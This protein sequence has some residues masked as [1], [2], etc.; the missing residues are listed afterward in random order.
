MGHR[1]DL[2]RGAKTC[3]L[4]L[5]YARTTARDI[6][7]ASGT[8]LASIG[9]HFGSKD[10]LM[11]AAMMEL[12]GDWGDR[13]SPPSMRDVEMPSLQRFSGAWQRLIEQFAAD[14]QLLIASFEIFAQ[15]QRLPDLKAMLAGAYEQ[16]R[17]EMALDFLTPT[18]DLEGKRFR[19][20]SSLLLALLS[21]LAAQHLADPDRAPTVDEIVDGLRYIGRSLDALPGE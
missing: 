18:P 7:A 20:V 4:E 19:A 10:A 9:Y 5:G 17:G 14:P 16:L 3:L 11:A 21:G 2:M 12:M 1:E 15:I 6:V 8:N 13:F